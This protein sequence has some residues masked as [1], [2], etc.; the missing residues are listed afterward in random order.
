ME[1]ADLSAARSLKT[2]E[3]FAFSSCRRISTLL[4]KGTSESSAGSV[5]GGLQ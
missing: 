2:L 1:Y 5:S 3:R 4:L